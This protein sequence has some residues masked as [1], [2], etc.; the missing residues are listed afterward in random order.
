LDV[1]PLGLDATYIRASDQM[2]AQPAYTKVL[3]L[4]TFVWVMYA[5]RALTVEELQHALATDELCSNTEALELDTVDA[6][7]GACA[8]LLV[9]SE[10]E[11]GS[12]IRPIH[13]SVQE[14]FRNSPNGVMEGSCMNQMNDSFHVHTQLAITCLSHLQSRIVEEPSTASSL[15]QN[16]PYWNPF[17]WYAAC[18]FDY[19]ILHCGH[20]SD[21]LYRQ[22]SILLE[23][24]G[25]FLAAVL[26]L[27]AVG[28]LCGCPQE[29]NAWQ[30]FNS[31]HSLASVSDMVYAT[32]LYNVP[33]F[34]DQWKGLTPAAFALHRACSGGSASAVAGL[35]ANGYN[36][37]ERDNAGISPIYYP[38]VRGNLPILRMLLE[39]GANVNIGGG[40]Y[41]TP[42]RTAVQAG[43]E[44]TIKLLLD[45][46]ANINTQ[47]GEF[48]SSLIAASDQGH[49]EIVMLL[50]KNGAD[51]NAQVG[52]YGTALEAASS[53][54]KMEIVKLLLENGADVNAQG[55]YCGTALEAV[56]L[57]GEIEIVKALLKNGADI[58]ARWKGKTALHCA[59]SGRDASQ[60]VVELLLSKDADINSRHEGRTALQIA[61]DAHQTKIVEL[62]LSKGAEPDDRKLEE[63]TSDEPDI[64]DSSVSDDVLEETEPTHVDSDAE[65][66]CDAKEAD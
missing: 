22:I 42:L 12:I 13:Y 26:Q 52:R 29:P 50:L 31:Y 43:H 45:H 64:S 34:Q 65:E 17:M 24:E 63:E 4:K 8:N 59:S 18:S 35:L 2:S 10:Y 44:K 7:L 28:H 40:N 30:N 39:K 14:F 38:A 33:G 60:G 61:S 15:L 16:H 62:L 49:T 37:D 1:L 48:G 19:H 11:R 53:S 25:W 36:A 58:H 21:E 54:G 9:V 23:R 27:R 20:L 32:E 47:G 5:K 55:G 51:V 46:N 57:N 66:T 6:I 56:S 41:Y 3:A